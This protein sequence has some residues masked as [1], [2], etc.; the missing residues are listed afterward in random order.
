MKIRKRTCTNPEPMNG[1]LDCL[2]QHLGPD[3]D[4]I[5]CNPAC[6]PGKVY[7]VMILF[8]LLATCF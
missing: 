7:F 6:C 2:D 3:E 5:E 1:G 8:Y 4:Q